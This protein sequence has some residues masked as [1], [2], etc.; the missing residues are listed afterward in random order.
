MFHK[1]CIA[2]RIMDFSP[3]SYFLLFDFCSLDFEV[4]VKIRTGLIQNLVEIKLK[5]E[6]SKRVGRKIVS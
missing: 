6:K 2:F 5:G 3:C 4:Y 1:C